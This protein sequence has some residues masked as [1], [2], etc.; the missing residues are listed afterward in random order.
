MTW[1][2]ASPMKLNRR[3]DQKLQADGQW[4][5][6]GSYSE[7]NEDGQLVLTGQFRMGKKW[8]RWTQFDPKLASVGKSGK[9]VA[10]KFF[11]NGEEIPNPNSAP[12]TISNPTSKK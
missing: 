11:E 4:I 7:W 1:P 6:H 3:C 10:E 12:N 5:N 9:V 2:Y 8:G